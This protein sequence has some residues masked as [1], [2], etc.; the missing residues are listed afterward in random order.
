M[1]LLTESE[2]SVASVE[3]NISGVSDAGPVID[4]KLD[5]FVNVE[6][7]LLVAALTTTTPIISMTQLDSI[8]II[9]TTKQQAYPQRGF[10]IAPQASQSKLIA[11]ALIIK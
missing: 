6:T 3:V 9:F 8:T 4:A 11:L 1:Y 5:T 10:L 7:L 2:T